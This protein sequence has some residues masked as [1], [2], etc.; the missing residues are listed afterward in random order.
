MKIHQTFRIDPELLKKVKIQAKKENRKVCNLF[1]TAII[2][3][4]KIRKV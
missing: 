2:E 1:E 4:L 3:Y